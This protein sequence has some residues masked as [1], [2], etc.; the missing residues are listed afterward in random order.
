MPG[1]DQ[2]CVSRRGA[3]LDEPTDNFAVPPT[4]LKVKLGCNSQKDAEKVLNITSNFPFHAFAKF[5]M[6]FHMQMPLNLLEYN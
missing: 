1:L 4:L 6:T 2:L 5:K 3:G